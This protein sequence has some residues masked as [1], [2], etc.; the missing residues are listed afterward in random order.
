MRAGQDPSGFIAEYLWHLFNF[1]ELVPCFPV[2]TGPPDRYQRSRRLLILSLLVALEEELIILRYF[3]FSRVSALPL[4]LTMIVLSIYHG[5]E[6]CAQIGSE[7]FP[8]QASQSRCPASSAP[9]PT[10]NTCENQVT[11]QHSAQ[12]KNT[13]V[14]LAF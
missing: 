11:G 10:Q 2:C 13:F 6:E 12:E 9:Q 8:I 4:F 14:C 3:L 7:S 5:D 1:G